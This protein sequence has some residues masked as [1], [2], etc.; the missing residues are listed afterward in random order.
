[1]SL[2]SL[3]TEEQQVLLDKWVPEVH[4][5]RPGHLDLLDLLPLESLDLLDTLG[6][7]DPEESLA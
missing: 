2:A 3:V 6:Q 5:V 7:W 4:L 1:M